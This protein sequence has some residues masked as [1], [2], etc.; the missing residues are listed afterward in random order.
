MVS[1]RTIPLLGRSSAALVWLAFAACRPDT[2]GGAA[3]IDSPRVLAIRSVPAEVEPGKPVAYSALYATPD[4]DSNSGAS[5]LSWALC[6]ARKPLAVAGPIA[7]ECLEPS[8]PDM[9]P[10]GEGPMAMG[11]L[12][13]D[14]CRVFGPSP[15]APKMGEPA[16]RPADPDSTGGYFQPLRVRA[17]ESN[18][19]YA[20]GFTRLLCGPGSATQEQGFEF[21]RSYR[22]NENPELSGGVQVDP[23]GDSR[24]LSE[25]A[26]EPTLIAAGERVTL[27]AAWA[28]CPLDASCGDGICGAG[29][30]RGNCPAY[31]KTPRGCTGSEPYP[32]VD[33]IASALVPRREAMRV[34]WFASAG[35]FAHDRSGRPADEADRPYSDNDWTPPLEAGDV[36]LWVVL[37]DDRGGVGYRSFYARVE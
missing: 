17:P 1:E 30:D 31:C 18:A 25:S 4:S 14:G 20:I 32:Y 12:P 29:E 16:A 22:P 13:A 6:T 35:N 3:L 37:R 15:P 19:E 27:R 36:R 28:D 24:E 23:D 11:M 21:A 7:L 9:I 34:S 2:E 8:G 33:P 5:R 10:L 26:E